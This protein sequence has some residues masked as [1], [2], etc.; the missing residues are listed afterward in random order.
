MHISCSLLPR[1]SYLSLFCVVLYT[2]NT[3]LCWITHQFALCVFKGIWKKTF[4]VNVDVL[5]LWK[6]E[7][8]ILCWL[9][10][11]LSRASLPFNMYVLLCSYLNRYLRLVRDVSRGCDLHAKTSH[12]SAAPSNE[13]SIIWC[14]GLFHKYQNGETNL[15]Y[16]NCKST[17]VYS[18]ILIVFTSLLPQIQTSK[19]KPKKVILLPVLQK[20]FGL[21]S[22][23]VKP[24]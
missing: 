4:F 17:Q 14:K 15:A 7:M 1:T 5:P 21:N 2:L 16:P 11:V 20:V 6:M 10:F 19:F 23:T 9:F 3:S 18:V 22:I 24:W 13:Y 12:P 8:Y